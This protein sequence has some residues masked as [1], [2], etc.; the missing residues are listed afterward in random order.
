MKKVF[1]WFVLISIL[2]V[3][4]VSVTLV[5]AE[6]VGSHFVGGFGETITKIF[7]SGSPLALENTTRLLLGALLWMVLFTT[8]QQT[9]IFPKGAAIWSGIAALI[10]TILTFMYLP[11]NIATAISAPYSAAG[12]SILTFIPFLIVLYFITSVTR[13]AV[14]A[15]TIWLVFLIYYFTIL[16]YKMFT[17][18]WVSWS[19]LFF[20]TTTA[21]YWIAI[22][23]GV[24]IFWRLEDIRMWAFKGK[25]VELKEKGRANAKKM[26]AALNV[27]EA[28]LKEAAGEGD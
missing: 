26:G 19:E 25:I 18:E 20:S 22:L 4:L 24:F 7:E 9:G 27:S 17:S 10:V 11:A 12:A 16:I 5:A 21:P 8:L 13:S 1:T 23:I 14:L 15:R 2:A 3:F 6:T 28:V